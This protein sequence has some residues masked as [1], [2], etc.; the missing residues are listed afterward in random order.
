MEKYGK[1]RPATGDN[2]IRR[3][4]FTCKITK[5]ANIHSEYVILIDFPR[6]LWLR[7][8]SSMLH[9]TYMTCLVFI[10]LRCRKYTFIIVS[11][12]II[13]VTGV[14]YVVET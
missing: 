6:R 1:S 3:M 2:I 13:H 12:L 8:R 4:R 5:A 7:E 9:G 10:M 11:R 14:N